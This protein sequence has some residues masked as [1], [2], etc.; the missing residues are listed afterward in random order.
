M[1]LNKGIHGSP[2]STNNLYRLVPLNWTPEVIGILGGLIVSFFLFGFFN[3]YWRTTDQDILMIYDA[4]LQNDGLPRQIALHPAH[5]IVTA[6]ST[7]YRALHGLGLLKTYSL[8]TLP[9]ASDAD[10]FNQAWT[11]VVHVARLL[12]LFFVLSYVTAFAFLLRWLVRD[13]R[14]AVLGMFAIAYS[15]GIAIGVRAVK[16]EMLSGAFVAIALLLLLIAARSPRTMGRPLLIGAAAL[17]ATLAMDNKVQAIFLIS[18][19]P[20][21]LL[22]FGEPSDHAGYW[23]QKGAGRSLAALVVAAL[24]A[25]AAA[26][27]LVHQGL[28]PDVPFPMMH[29]VFGT[30]VFNALLAVSIGLGMLVFG[31]L[32]RV[33]I[34]EG[35]AAAAALVGGV[36][37]GLLPLYIHREAISVATVINPIDA[38]YY[39][40]G[41]SAYGCGGGGCGSLPTMLFYSFR[42]MLAHHSFFLQ[43][44]PRPE[45]F[46]E[47]AVIAGIVFA[48]RRGEYKAALQAT[49]LIGAGM[50]ID[51]LQAARAL[52]ID[53]FHFTDP[54]III[55]AVILCA[56]VTSLQYHRWIYPIGALL[57][58]LHIVLSQAEPLKE[59]YLLRSGPETKCSILND[60]PRL[61][62]FPFCRN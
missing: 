56:K 13:W 53:Y 36:A 37:L 61:E 57:I 11:N 4:F 17:S 25:V 23:S 29:L 26:T 42:T 6:L 45:I 33:P 7:T 5:L 35:L 14:T 12:C 54:L 60:L 58:G 43:T 34:K 31:R 2:A 55:A 22:P 21:L 27:P 3:P 28:F 32:W 44:S 48:C 50:G 8:S 46:L 38:L 47:W 49:F 39:Y 51:I 10:A 15:G 19:L 24:L 62:R 1:Q 52:K 20:V 9:P 59:S 30:G 40:S 16:P 41:A 18:A